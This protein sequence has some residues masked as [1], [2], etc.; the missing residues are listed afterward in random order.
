MGFER[1]YQ[2]KIPFN[3]IL[4]KRYSTSPGGLVP[5]GPVPGPSGT[6][7]FLCAARKKKQCFS[8]LYMK[9]KF[10]LCFFFLLAASKKKNQ[11]SDQEK[12]NNVFH[13]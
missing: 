10:F 7:F 3:Q 5:S 11:P 8:Y 9:N 4:Q 13:I 6:S 1:N 2:V 12:K